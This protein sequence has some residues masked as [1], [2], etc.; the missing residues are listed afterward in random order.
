MLFFA[1]IQVQIKT[2][3]K[4]NAHTYPGEAIGKRGRVNSSK[5]QVCKLTFML[6]FGSMESHRHLTFSFP[7]TQNQK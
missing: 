1:I 7:D 6:D 4:K 3:E 5:C 2:V